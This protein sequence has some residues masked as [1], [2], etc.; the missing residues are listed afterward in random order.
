MN[1]A[2]PVSIYLYDQCPVCIRQKTNK[3][4]KNPN[5]QKHTQQQQQTNKTNQ[6]KTKLFPGARTHFL[7]SRFC[8][9]FV[10]KDEIFYLFHFL[11]SSEQQFVM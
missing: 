6:T 5:Q 9:Y 8:A 7:Y 11:H 2:I 1:V 4:T 3:Q 10:F